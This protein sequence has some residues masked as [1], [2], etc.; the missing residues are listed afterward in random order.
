MHSAILIFNIQ[1]QYR[2]FYT[3]PISNLQYLPHIFFKLCNIQDT[4]CNLLSCL[5][6]VLYITGYLANLLPKLFAFCPV[7]FSFMLRICTVSLSVDRTH[8]RLYRLQTVQM[9]DN[10]EVKSTDDRQYRQKTVE[11]VESTNVDSTDERQYKWQTVQTV[12]SIGG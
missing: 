8:S 1:F 5:L 12:G 11:T 4:I 7:V 10:T 6:T 9:V 2:I 3:Y